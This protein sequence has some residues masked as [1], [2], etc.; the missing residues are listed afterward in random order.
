MNVVTVD[1]AVLGDGNKGL[2]IGPGEADE[3]AAGVAPDGFGD[4]VAGGGEESEFAE[5]GFGVELDDFGVVADEGNGAAKGGA[6]DFVTGQVDV[7][8]GEGVELG[9]AVVGVVQM[10]PFRG[11]CYA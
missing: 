8:P 7:F 1:G 3:A 11:Y 5:G 10:L 6:G 9:F 4:L 2:G